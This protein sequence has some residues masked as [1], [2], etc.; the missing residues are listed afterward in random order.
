[1]KANLLAFKNNSPNVGF[2]M[3]YVDEYVVV[4]DLT[5]ESACSSVTIPR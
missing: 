3:S 1:M 2:V 4:D 5:V